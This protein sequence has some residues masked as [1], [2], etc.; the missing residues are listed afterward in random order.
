MQDDL[1]K[2]DVE[3]RLQAGRR[4][5]QLGRGARSFQVDASQDDSLGP[6][7][8]LQGTW[9]SSEQGWNLIALPFKGP[10]A[11]F[12][13]RLLMNQYGETLD[14]SFV[15]ENIPN[16]GITEDAEGVTDQLITGLDYQQVI[17]QVA[18]ADSPESSLRSVD[19]KG[20]HH[21]PGLFLHIMNHTAEHNGES[22]RIAR[23]ATI[24]HGDSVLA[25]GKVDRLV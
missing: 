6:L 8:E 22:L 19:G 12:D 24:P 1:K 14:F 10:S 9:S 3:K 11:P 20:I 13:Y 15:D 5:R 17:H 4:M 7:A 18:S 2:S 16:R 23:L 25:M 21:E